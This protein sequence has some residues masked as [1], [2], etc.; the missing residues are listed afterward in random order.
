ML[1]PRSTAASQA[2]GEDRGNSVRSGRWLAPHSVELA[3]YRVPEAIENQGR[4]ADPAPAVCVD[5]PDH[6]T[7]SRPSNLFSANSSRRRGARGE[8]VR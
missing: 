4:V 1:T 3:I 8:G 7:Y 2:K 5:P 6:P